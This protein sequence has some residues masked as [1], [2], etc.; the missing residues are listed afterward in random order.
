MCTPTQTSNEFL[1][2]FRYTRLP[3]TPVFPQL[4][5]PEKSC[6]PI[7]ST[8]MYI[9]L[10]SYV[11]TVTAFFCCA[12]YTEICG[13]SPIPKVYSRRLCLQERSPCM[14]TCALHVL[15]TCLHMFWQYMVTCACVTDEHYGSN[16]LL[17]TI[18][19]SCIPTLKMNLL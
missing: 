3:Q 19:K 1:K 8:H 11:Y 6:T 9:V 16:P 5:T 2:R 4:P 15:Y 12:T 7:C 17:L 13:M 18:E 10:H 14:L